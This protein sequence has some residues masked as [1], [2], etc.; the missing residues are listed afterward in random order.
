MAVSQLTSFEEIIGYIAAYTSQ[1]ESSAIAVTLIVIALEILALPALLGLQIHNVVRALSMWA[2]LLAPL[3]WLLL[4]LVG[5]GVNAEV[6][7][8]LFGKYLFLPVGIVAILYSLL[9]TIWGA[10]CWQ[11]L[12][13][14]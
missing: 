5:L 4:M 8:G 13:Q 6:T 14:S 3:S 9:L 10:L 11:Q 7:S 2:I 1:T 12:K